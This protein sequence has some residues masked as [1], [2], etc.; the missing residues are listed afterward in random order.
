MNHYFGIG[1][2]K[3]ETLKSP[4]EKNKTTKL[5]SSGKFQL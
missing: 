5:E 1:S 2:L 3:L 4:A